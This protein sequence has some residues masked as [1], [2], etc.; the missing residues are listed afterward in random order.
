MPR[1]DIPD[2]IFAAAYELVRRQGLEFGA[3]AEQ[4]LWSYAQR[5]AADIQ[6][7]AEPIQELRVQEAQQAFR[8]VA[9]RMMR[10]R[11]EIPGYAS[12]NPGIV[13]EDTL[14]AASARGWPFD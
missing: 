9:T 12:A 1:P 3:G 11:L 4:Q 13:G 10:A 14:A 5:A 7:T 2:R 8:L 6:Q